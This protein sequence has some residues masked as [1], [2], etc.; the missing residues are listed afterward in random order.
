MNWHALLQHWTH[1]WPG[2]ALAAVMAEVGIVLGLVHGRG[3]IHKYLLSPIMAVAIV[4]LVVVVGGIT[5][6]VVTNL[7]PAYATPYAYLLVGLIPVLGY[8]AGRMAG[9]TW[10]DTAHQRGSLVLEGVDAQD[11]RRRLTRTLRGQGALRLAGVPVPPEDETKHFKL[12]GTTGTGK[13]TAIRELVHGALTR[14]DRAVIADPDGG[15]LA[16]FYDPTKGDVILNPFDARSLRWD[17]FAEIRAVY[18]VEQLARSLIPDQEGSERTWRGYARTFFTAVTRQ[19]HAAGVHDTAELYRLLTAASTEELRLLVGGTPAQPFLD[20]GNER[21]FG[22]IRSVTGVGVAALEY[23]QMQRADAFSV[24]DW[25]DQ[26]KGVLFLPYQADQI[27]ALR[28]VIATWMRLAIFQAMSAGEGDRRL[29]FIVDELDALGAIDGLKDAL[30]RLS[31]GAACWGSSPSPRSPAPTAR[32]RR[33][34]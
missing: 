11:H 14:G 8:V 7:A 19:A 4:A 20:A 2:M 28:S 12:I 13:S 26:G 17:L 25:V 22:S 27:A 10:L 23:V 18:D 32:G 21:M 33:G 24:R 5:M 6:M 9:R 1:G 16:R 31:V 15:Y 3:P 30:A 29:W 34:P